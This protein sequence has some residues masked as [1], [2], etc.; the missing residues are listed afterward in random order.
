MKEFY[1]LIF[2]RKS[3][4]RV[5]RRYDYSAINKYFAHKIKEEQL[6]IVLRNHVDL[7]RRDI[8]VREYEG[9]LDG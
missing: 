4:G 6:L 3:D 1:T 8:D 9:I 2:V 5:L 7:E